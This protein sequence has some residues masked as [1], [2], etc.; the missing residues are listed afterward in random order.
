MTDP[1][2]YLSILLGLGGIYVLISSF[3]DDDDGDDD[4][5]KYIYN[6]KYTELAG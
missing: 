4:G 1:I 5:G 3:D 2:L 6:L